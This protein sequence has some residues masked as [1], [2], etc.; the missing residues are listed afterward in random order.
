MT[1]LLVDA[2]SVRR[3][4][5]QAAFIMTQALL[6]PFVADARVTVIGTE[7]AWQLLDEPLRRVAPGSA[8]H[9]ALVEAGRRMHKQTAMAADRADKEQRSAR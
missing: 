2:A 7:A 5:G 6:L 4:L 3:A 8:R 1:G 9:L